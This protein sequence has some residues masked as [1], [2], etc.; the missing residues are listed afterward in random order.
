VRGPRSP[1]LAW[2][3]RTGDRVYA[4]VA[5]SQGDAVYVVS[6][7]HKLYAVGKDGREL[8]SYDTGGKVWTTPAVAKDGSIYVGTD[9]DKIIALSSDGAKKWTFSTRPEEATKTKEPAGRYDVDTS[10][11]I[12][13]D[14]TVYFGCHNLFLGLSPHG[15]IAL[16]FLAGTSKDKIFSSPAMAD[17]GTLY[18][19]TQGRYFFALPKTGKPLW[20]V[21]TD[22]DNDSSPVVGDDGTVFFGSDDGK[23]RAVAPGGALR[24][25][26]I[27]GGAIRAPL[28]L[29]H[30]GAVLAPTSGPVP[31]LV[32]VDART[33][34]ERW[35]FAIEPGQGDFYGIQGGAAVDKDGT[36]YFGG[37][38]HFIYSLTQDGKLSWRYETGD[39]VDSGA[40][41][42]PDGT[43]YIGSDDKRVYAFRD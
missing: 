10:P 38:D 31:A 12:G 24:F 2:V 16:S 34:Q 36:I 8:W 33:G 6:H 15:D 17:D 40:V 21:T 9:E 7:D 5:L 13:P 25:E 41:L 19:G 29:T 39:Q 30:D 43:L 3:F 22:G 37:R 27:L 20:T 26:V 23:L 35:R 1:K 32:A 42:G 11:V 28:S 18:F 14:G 4:D